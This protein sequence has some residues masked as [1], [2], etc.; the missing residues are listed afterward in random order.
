[1]AIQARDQVTSNGLRQSQ[2]QSFTPLVEY[3]K[4]G[5]WEFYARWQ[6]NQET[7]EQY[8]LE[9]II[10]QY[11]QPFLDN[12]RQLTY[13]FDQVALKTPFDSLQVQFKNNQVLQFHGYGQEVEKHYALAYFER[14]IA[15][16]YQFNALETS[17]IPPIQH[18]GSSRRQYPVFIQTLTRTIKAC[19]ELDENGDK[20]GKWTYFSKSGEKVKETVFYVPEP[21]HV[22]YIKTKT[23]T[24]MAENISRSH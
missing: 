18:Y 21:I 12:F 22:P 17:S 23:A 4:Q 6:P 9:N 3:H 7:T 5:D 14:E 16:T 2:F 11:Y 15:P 10:R 1:M 13:R 19:G 8:G 20:I 24:Q